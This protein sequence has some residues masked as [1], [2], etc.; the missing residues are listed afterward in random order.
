LPGIPA[1]G[2]ESTMLYVLFEG[3]SCA[4]ERGLK[5]CRVADQ[6]SRARN[7]GYIKPSRLS[8]NQSG[9]VGVM[10]SR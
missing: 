5:S 10:Q 8:E 7:L 4:I 1:S 9:A 6:V 3:K 2:W